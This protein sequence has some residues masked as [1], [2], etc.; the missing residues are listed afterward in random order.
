MDSEST[1]LERHSS[2]NDLNDAEVE[3]KTTASTK[4]GMDASGHATADAVTTTTATL[5]GT[6]K[7]GSG[8]DEVEEDIF[9]EVKMI[10][11]K[12]RGWGP[13]DSLSANDLG[14]LEYDDELGEEDD[15]G[16]PLPSTP[17]DTQLIEAEVSIPFSVCFPQRQKRKKQLRTHVRK[18]L[19][20]TH[21]R[22]VIS[23][24]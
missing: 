15:A 10:L 1:L 3:V 11:R 24:C 19:S 9:E 5:R 8:S 4:F 21:Q 13:E 16:C 14:L 18:P 17:E 22:V 7:I 23:T 12:R 6:N 2:T 20:L